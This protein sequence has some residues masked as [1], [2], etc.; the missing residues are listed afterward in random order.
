MPIELHIQTRDN[1]E[2]GNVEIAHKLD[3]QDA[4]LSEIQAFYS[5]LMYLVR[6][7]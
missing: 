7:T 6:M 3:P 5:K 1:F 2:T 4:S